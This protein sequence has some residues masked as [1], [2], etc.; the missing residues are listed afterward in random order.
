MLISPANIAAQ[1]SNLTS[2]IG[3]QNPYQWPIKN[4]RANL[5][6]QNGI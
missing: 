4:Y 2:Q 5:N 1:S 3:I 6:T